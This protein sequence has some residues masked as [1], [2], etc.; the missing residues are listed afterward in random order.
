MTERELLKIARKS[1]KNID[2]PKRPWYKGY[3]RDINEL[4]WYY[5]YC[6]ILMTLVRLKLL[7]WYRWEAI[8]F[9]RENPYW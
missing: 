6:R 5:V 4:W 8:C 7:N 1:T 2:I 3:M 9:N